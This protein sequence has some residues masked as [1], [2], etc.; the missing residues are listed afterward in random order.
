[1]R[2]LVIDLRNNPGGSLTD[3]V[4][5]A[6]TLLGKGTIVS[7]RGR[8]EAE[9]KEYSSNAKGVEV[10]MAV[11]VNENSA[12]ASEILAA[13]VQDF[14]AGIVVGMTT[15]GKGVVQTTMQIEGNR[16]WL[17]LTT[18]AYYTPKGA[19]IDGTGVTPDIEIDLPEELKGLAIDEIEQDDDAQLWAALDYVRALANETEE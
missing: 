17:K 1:M 15:Y 14:E 2:S 4:S 18:D 5:I 7:V 12:S 11:L 16:A 3:V 9:G 13:A 19:N 6:D 8:L 10:P